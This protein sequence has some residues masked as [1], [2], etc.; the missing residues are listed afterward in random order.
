MIEHATPYEFHELLAMTD[1]DEVREVI[2]DYVEDLCGYRVSIADR[3]HA[4]MYEKVV[5]YHPS[6]TKYQEYR[7]K[8]G[9][10]DGLYQAWYEN[11]AIMNQYPLVNGGL[12]GRYKRWFSNGELQMDLLVCAW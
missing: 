3:V 6:G 9:V 2:G 8:F 12:R 5:T 7:T 4:M 10:R 11:G 1:L